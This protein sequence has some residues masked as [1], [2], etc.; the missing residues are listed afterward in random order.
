MRITHQWVE[1]SASKPPAAPPAPVYPPDGGEADGT[2]IVFQWTPAQDPDGD[3]DRRLPLRAV[4]PRRHAVAAVDVLLQ[5]HLPNRRRDQGERQRHRQ[6]QDHRQGPIHLAPAGPADARP[7]VLL[8]RAGHG[9]QG[10]VGAV[11]QDLELH[12]PRPGVSAERHARLRPG[13]GHGHSPLESQPR[14]PSARQVPGLRQRREGFHGRRPAVSRAPWASRRRRWRHGTR[15]SRRTSS[16]R[17]T[18]TELAVLGPRRRLARGQQDLL[19]R[20]GGGRAG[21]AQRAVRLRDR[22]PARDLQQAGA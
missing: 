21:Q 1:R 11:E 22:P 14:R 18:A 5:A 10:R 6:G 9:R 16:P 20:G 4:E 3:A 12:P 7:A 17:P 8:A 19:P 15:G 13:Q 2:D